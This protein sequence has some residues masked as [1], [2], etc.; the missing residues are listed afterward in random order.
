MRYP[1]TVPTDIPFGSETAAGTP[2]ALLPNLSR[3]SFRVLPFQGISSDLT[4]SLG[5]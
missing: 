3:E 4:N 1:L 5:S 2:A